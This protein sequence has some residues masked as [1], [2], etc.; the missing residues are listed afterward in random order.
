[1]WHVKVIQ[2]SELYVYTPIWLIQVNLTTCAGMRM[3]KTLLRF[4]EHAHPSQNNRL[5]TL[6]SAGD[7]CRRSHARH[8]GLL[9]GWCLTRHGPSISSVFRKIFWVSSC[10][11]H[12]FRIKVMHFYL[13][14]F[15]HP[16]FIWCLFVPFVVLF[17]WVLIAFYHLYL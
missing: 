6:P 11:F 7:L 17:N 8:V 16:W 5:T 10:L 14:Y 3:M 13:I 4:T 15:C 2:L 12:V 1:M 9:G